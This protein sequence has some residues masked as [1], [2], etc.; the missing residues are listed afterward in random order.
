MIAAIYYPL[1]ALPVALQG[2][3]ED[4][5]KVEKGK[6]ARLSLG[7]TLVGIALVF[8]FAA[9]D[10]GKVQFLYEQDADNVQ[11]AAQHKDKAIV[12]LYNPNN[13]WMIWDESEEMMQYDEIYFISLADESAITDSTILES[14]EIY[15]YASRMDAAESIMESLINDNSKLENPEKIRELLYCDLY[16]L[17]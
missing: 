17:K 7:T 12:Y 14:D 2:E 13:V 3:T 1:K 8:Q 15:V 4:K 10:Q 9:L 5:N 16:Y 6:K 11:W